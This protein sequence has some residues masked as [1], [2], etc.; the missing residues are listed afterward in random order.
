MTDTGELLERLGASLNDD[1]E[2]H[3]VLDELG[4]RLE[5]RE[6]E[7]ELFCRD[8]GDLYEQHTLLTS[9]S[10]T[11]GSVIGLEKAAHLILREVVEV[12]EA[13]RAALWRMDEDRGGLTLLAVEGRENVAG[14]AGG[15][16]QVRALSRK[17]FESQEPLLLGP[18]ERGIQIGVEQVMLDAPGV[19]LLSVPVTYSPPEGSTRRVG[20]LNV[21]R[22]KEGG[23][24]MAGDLN[25]LI[26]IASQIGSAVET[27]R[28]V[29]QTVRRE[30]LAAEMRLAH[31]LQ[32][33][34]LPDPAGFA[35]LGR[36]AARCEPAES[37]GG[38]FYQ[39]FRLPR[40]RLGVMIGD[41]S[42]HGISAALIMAGAMSA[43]AICAREEERPSQVLRRV[44]AELLR[45]LRST[46]MHITLFY[47]VLDA[48]GGSLSY[49]SAGHPHAHRLAEDDE[50]RLHALV[51]PLGPS[52]ME[53]YGERT[54][55]W[56]RGTD[57]LLLFTDGLV[58]ELEGDRLAAEARLTSVARE[59]LDG[60]V[61]SLLDAIFGL[62]DGERGAADDRT[63]VAVH[64]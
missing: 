25:L 38:D 22:E 35:D 45:D 36:I 30:R 39:I 17:V 34:L 26:A 20:V 43:A 15:A 18:E 55:D 1:P 59:H 21:L 56:E 42:S 60:R 48:A 19:P 29:R 23:S 16:G 2:A 27:R 10:E 9:I 50:A 52:P 11:L 12:L 63:A 41:V 44:H 54:V 4:S 58:E 14:V 24:F 6:R 40:S 8:L 31:D 3:R 37:V 46:E 7:N 64:L 51:P 62:S 57:H 13:S 32:L 28:L 61:E 47:G 49:A 5:E 33:K 53:E